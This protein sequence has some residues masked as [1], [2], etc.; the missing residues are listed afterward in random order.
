M[1]RTAA[2]IGIVAFAWAS[3]LLPPRIKITTKIVRTAICVL[4][5]VR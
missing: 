4:A 2:I 3:I 5:S 1:S